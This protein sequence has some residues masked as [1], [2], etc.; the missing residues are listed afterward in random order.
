M[1]SISGS[2]LETL[3]LEPPRRAGI[4]IEGTIAGTAINVITNGEP[5]MRHNTARSV[6]GQAVNSQ[7]G[8]P[9][10]LPAKDRLPWRRY[11]TTV[12]DRNG[13]RAGSR[14]VA[15]QRAAGDRPPARRSAA[16]ARLAPAHGADAKCMGQNPGAVMAAAPVESG[17]KLHRILAELEERPSIDY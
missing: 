3:P 16:T 10:G 17:P 2:W 14:D 12:A 15:R 1:G 5:R 11:G 13:R 8:R 9:Q 6:W 4:R 7:L